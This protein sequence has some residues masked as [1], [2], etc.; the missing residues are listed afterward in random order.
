VQLPGG[1]AGVIRVDGHPTKALAFSSDVTPRYVAAD[2]FEGGKQ[3]VAECWRNLSASGATPLACSDNLNFGNPEKPRIMGQLVGAIKGIGEACRALNFP[4]VSGNV[5]LYNETNG[6]GI[7]PTP[8]IAGV[9]LLADWSIMARIGFAA[10]NQV[11]L[12]VGAPKNWGHHLSQSQY[13]AQIHGTSDGPPPPVDLDHE[14]K[15]GGFVR[16]L[17]GDGLATAVHDCSGGGLG[18]VLAE[19]AM[20]GNIGATI[21]PPPGDKLAGSFFGEDQG[22]YVLTCA[23]EDLPGIVELAEKSSI[24]VQQIGR[25]GGTALKLADARA[26]SVGELTAAHQGWFP[27]YMDG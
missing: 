17:V 18:V 19:M 10:E 21:S 16:S 27:A 25:T 2:P 5:S 24:S 3:A 22:R 20:A 15:T 8:T 9:G 26:I 6:V 23:P 14:K 13:L 11:I 7:P 12:L 4:V 1:D